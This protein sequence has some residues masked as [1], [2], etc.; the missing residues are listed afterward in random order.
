MREPLSVALVIRSFYQSNHLTSCVWSKVY[1]Q[2]SSGDM[3]PQGH[4]IVMSVPC[5]IGKD[6][7]T[8]FKMNKFL[9]K[10]L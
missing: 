4:I 10:N 2:F 8:S 6:Y 7:E 5:D 1:G 3:L 9:K